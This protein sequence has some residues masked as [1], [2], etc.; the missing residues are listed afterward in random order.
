MGFAIGVMI[1]IGLCGG[2][3]AQMPMV[4]LV[5]SIGWRESVG[6]LA[7]IGI[8]ILVLQ[9]IFI[10]D[11]PNELSIENEKIRKTLF[12][13]VKNKQN[14]LCATYTA[15]L[16]LPV[17]ILGATW[18]NLFLTQEHGITQSQAAFVLSMI[19]IGTIIS[20]SFIGWL[21]DKLKRRKLVMIIGG[22]FALF[23]VM[24]IAFGNIFTVSTLAILFF[25]LGFI[26]SAQSI[27]Y[28]TISESNPFQYTGIALGFA[29]SIIMGSAIVFQPLF[30][31]LIEQHWQITIFNTTMNNYR[32]AF[33]II[34][35]GF[36]F[37][38][39]C[40]IFI[41]ETYCVNYCETITDKHPS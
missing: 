1:T 17:I 30:G 5:N 27:S 23:I 10:V 38:I 25:L 16:D 36:I 2:I 8:I 35:V 32:I 21:S 19:Y 40:T 41:K 22:I 12:H 33:L 14:W 18:G 24:P 3:V 31:W 13:V 37:S 29:S 34:P 4:K 7:G 11:H 28:P 20:S 26:I 9:W 39:L 6:L 15:L